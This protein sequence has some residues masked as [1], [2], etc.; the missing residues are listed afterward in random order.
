MKQAR[1]KLTVLSTHHAS[2]VGVTK[3]VHFTTITSSA[4]GKGTTGTL[5][6]GDVTIIQRIG[7]TTGYGT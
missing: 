5:A 2:Q 3:G 7:A 6:G 1:A 4:C